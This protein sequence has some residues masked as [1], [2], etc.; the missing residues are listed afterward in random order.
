MD[1]RQGQ[2]QGLLHET[3]SEEG[4]LTLHI[5]SFNP[6]PRLLPSEQGPIFFNY[7][8]ET[9]VTK[10]TFLVNLEGGCE[11][12]RGHPFA[13]F[14]LSFRTQCVWVAGVSANKLG[15]MPPR[16]LGQC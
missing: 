3:E 8:Q 1:E 4:N 9:P 6:E 10:D 12:P 16:D 2:L 7:V 13:F 14:T 15:S 11:E 5:A